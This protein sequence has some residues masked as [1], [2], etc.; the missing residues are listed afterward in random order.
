VHHGDWRFSRHGSRPPGDAIGPALGLSRRRA[1]SE[2]RSRLNRRD[3]P[4]SVS[5]LSSALRFS[6]KWSA[7]ILQTRSAGSESRGCRTIAALGR[8][9]ALGAWRAAGAKEIVFGLA[10]VRI[11]SL[12]FA[13]H[14]SAATRLPPPEI[15]VNCRPMEDVKIKD[16]RLEDS[17]HRP[18]I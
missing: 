10:S 18:V 11:F 5:S 7:L 12:P 1:R 13:T 17:F 8:D 9:R 4:K 14:R 16:A 15:P 3:P 2:F 6:V